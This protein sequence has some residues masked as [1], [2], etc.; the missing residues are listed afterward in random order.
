MQDQFG[1]TGLFTGLELSSCEQKFLKQISDGRFDQ[2][3][4]GGYFSHAEAP[5][6]CLP[7]I[8][9]LRPDD[10][11]VAMNHAECFERHSY[12]IHHCA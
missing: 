6:I 2:K 5:I 9:Q 4:A 8:I 3:V 1:E 10:R 11:A 7:A 12:G